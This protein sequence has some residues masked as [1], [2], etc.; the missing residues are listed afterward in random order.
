MVKI[1]EKSILKILKRGCR[2]QSDLSI[3]SLTLVEAPSVP[4]LR[5]A[6]NYLYTAKKQ[7]YLLVCNKKCFLNLNLYV[8]LLFGSIFS[9]Y[10]TLYE[11]LLKYNLPL[12]CFNLLHSSIICLCIKAASEWGAKKHVS[13]NF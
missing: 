9:I 10:M 3:S 5:F 12:I 4:L 1:F 6:R 8:L 11:M 13:R 7:H 2:T